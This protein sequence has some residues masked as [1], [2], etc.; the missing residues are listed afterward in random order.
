[1][2]GK[3]FAKYGTARMS[4]EEF[5]IIQGELID[6]LR[7]ITS[8]PFFKIPQ[9]ADKES[10]GDIDLCVNLK[11]AEIRKL[12]TEY[13]LTKGTFQSPD[14]FSFVFSS[15]KVEGKDVQVDF[16]C[17]PCPIFAKNFM[18][19]NGLVSMSLGR[20][21]K[22]LGMKMKADGL[23]FINKE[24]QNEILVTQDFTTVMNML[25]IPQMDTMEPETEEN[26][27]RNLK[28]SRFFRHMEPITHTERDHK[29][30]VYDE[31]LFRIFSSRI[32][33]YHPGFFKKVEEDTKIFK[34]AS[35]VRDMIRRRY[36]GNIVNAL[37]GLSERHLGDFMKLYKDSKG[38]DFQEFIEN[39]T[40]ESLNEDI[41]RFYE[42][43]TQNTIP[44]IITPEK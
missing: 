42:R 2:G 5:K 29:K 28:K 32:E 15:E 16:I 26:V 17:T 19:Y 43:T 1:M 35:E 37:T 24:T 12:V 25:E 27:I 14:S 6:N 13:F 30:T 40:E 22:A 41:L 34:E 18:A 9:L 11:P 39:S 21:C 38:K 44:T 20:L 33:E 8:I 23:F 7:K 4:C 3:L 10:H 36:N 31:E